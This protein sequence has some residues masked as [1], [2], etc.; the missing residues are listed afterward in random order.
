[1]QLLYQ[2]AED[3]GTIAYEISE[4]SL[5]STYKEKSA[6]RTVLDRW[7]AVLEAESVGL[8]RAEKAGVVARF[9]K[10]FLGFAK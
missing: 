5:Q 9:N 8:S 10:H 4:L 2:L 3:Y 6:L 1:M 7:H